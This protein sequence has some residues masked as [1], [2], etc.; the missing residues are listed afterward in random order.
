SYIQNH[1]IYIPF[2]IIV[3]LEAA[4]YALHLGANGLY[5]INEVAPISLPRISIEVKEGGISRAISSLNILEVTPIMSSGPEET[6]SSAWTRS[7]WFSP[8]YEDDFDDEL[9]EI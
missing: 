3:R 7:V 2:I 9:F 5:L 4:V 1:N 8:K 6:N